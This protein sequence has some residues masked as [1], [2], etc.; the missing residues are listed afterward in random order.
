MLTEFAVQT[1]Q[2]ISV[3][4]AEQSHIML[5]KIVLSMKKKRMLRNADFVMLFLKMP[6]RIFVQKGNAEINHG[7][8]VRLFSSAVTLAME[9]IKK[10]FIHPVCILIVS[11]RMKQ[12]LLMRMQIHIALFVMF[13]VWERNQ[14]FNSAASISFILI[15]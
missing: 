6:I 1:V 15:V 14:P 7:G 10:L 9:V 2:S 12:R 5:A 8:V 11:K 3:Y 4:L 13:K